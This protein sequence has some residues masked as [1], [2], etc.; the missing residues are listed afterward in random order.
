MSG[1]IPSVSR[2]LLKAMRSTLRCYVK[3]LRLLRCRLATASAMVASQLAWA[4]RY[5]LLRVSSLLMTLW[6]NPI[7]ARS[8]SASLQLVSW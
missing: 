5:Q 3:N 2:G 6:L 8:R 4:G 7:L 1:G